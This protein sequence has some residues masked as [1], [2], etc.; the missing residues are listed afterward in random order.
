MILHLQ[1][2][3]TYEQLSETCGSASII[4][5]TL[6]LTGPPQPHSQMTLRPPLARRSKVKGRSKPADCSCTGHT[7]LEHNVRVRSI[8]VK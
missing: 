1:I 6:V 7:P 5:T 2:L 8:L 3:S 4:R